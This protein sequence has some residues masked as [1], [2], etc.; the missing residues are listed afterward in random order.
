MK[1]TIE[2]GVTPDASVD[3]TKEVCPMTYVR[4]KLALERLVRGNVL[5]VWLTGE[6]PLRNIPRSALADGHEV[7]SLEAVE[8]RSRLLIRA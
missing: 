3:I 7:V 5:E 4:V 6:E 1:L 8:G 2:C